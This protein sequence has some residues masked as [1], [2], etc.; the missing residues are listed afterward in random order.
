M[1]N[2]VSNAHRGKWIKEGRGADKEH[3]ERPVKGKRTKA[4]LAAS[5]GDGV[6]MDHAIDV[7]PAAAVGGNQTD[8]QHQ[9]L[10][11]KR[12]K[13]EH[14][15]S[16]G[17]EVDEDNA[18]DV[19][20]NV[21]VHSLKE[22]EKS[23]KPSRL[24]INSP[25]DKPDPDANIRELM[26]GKLPDRSLTAVS[27]QDASFDYHRNPD[28]QGESHSDNRAMIHRAKHDLTSVSIASFGTPVN[29]NSRHGSE[30]SEAPAS[31]VSDTSSAASPKNMEDDLKGTLPALELQIHDAAYLES[32]RVLASLRT[33]GTHE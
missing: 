14:I 9:E 31:L 27:G 32:A 28:I 12:Q 17:E 3:Q 30:L 13:L 24:V 26:H 8:V 22:P 18:T 21:G 4:Q 15:A 10:A 11:R 5:N 16:D 19:D 1:V 20:Y 7:S 2:A 6:D 29:S 25:P 23:L 33:G